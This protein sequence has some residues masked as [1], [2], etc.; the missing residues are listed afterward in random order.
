MIFSRN[1]TYAFVLSLIM[2]LISWGIII[3]NAILRVGTLF[4]FGI[5]SIDAFAFTLVTIA[6]SIYTIVILFK[7]S[8]IA[9]FPLLL[10]LLHM[11]ALRGNL[12]LGAFVVADLIIFT[13]LN[14][15]RKVQ[16]N[17]LGGS[18]T[19]YF[20]T[21]STSGND[22]EPASVNSKSTYTNSDI[23]DVEFESKG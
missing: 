3:I 22:S 13:L 12:I 21:Y 15:G 2:V 9:Y 14:T 19:C 18:Q 20:N 4:Q 23:I 7:F 17:N 6:F 16:V 1:K 5:Y 8:N 10:V 11:S